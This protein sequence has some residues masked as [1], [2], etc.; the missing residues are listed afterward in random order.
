[1]EKQNGYV[2]LLDVLGFT[3]IVSGEDQ[4]EKLSQYVH[5]LG[6]VTNGTDVEIVLFS[7]TIVMTSLGD[8]PES[9]L[10]ILRPCSQAFGLLLSREIAVRGAISYGSF[11]RYKN[12]KGVFLAGR[13]IID[14]YRFQQEQDWVGIMLAPSVVSMHSDLKQ[15]CNILNIRTPDE[16][17]ALSARFAWAL[18]VQDCPSIPFHTSDPSEPQLYEGFAIVPTDTSIQDAAAMEEN[19]GR[20]LK[21][22]RRLK[23][24]SPHPKSQKKYSGA[25]TWLQNVK[26]RWAKVA[27]NSR[28]P[29][30]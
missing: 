2:A 25:I 14:A 4:T 6:M 24:L 16:I 13:A 28:Y 1:M 19:L 22:M 3:E 27:V 9:L 30:G 8:T 29:S 18:F 5:S 7:D 21:Y 20:V 17:Q 23:S 12:P 26:S 10:S 11:I 15:R